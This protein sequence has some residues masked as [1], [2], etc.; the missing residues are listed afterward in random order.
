MESLQRPDNIPVTYRSSAAAETFEAI[1][2]RF[3]Q[4]FLQVRFL[5]YSHTMDDYDQR[6]LRI[7][8]QINFFQLIAGLCLPLLGMVLHS[9][10]P[11]EVWLIACGPALVSVVVLLLNAFRQYD[12]SLYAYFILYPLCSCF[13]Y[14]NG[15]NPGIELMFILFVILS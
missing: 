6:K 1:R 3:A 5:G 15:I 4:L 10:V 14:L 2:V 11:T 12:I 8:N 9:H 7:F 13:V